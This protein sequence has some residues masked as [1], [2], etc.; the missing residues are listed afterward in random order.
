ME[1]STLRSVSTLPGQTQPLTPSAQMGDR[2]VGAC[3]FG[4]IHST[5]NI[6]QHMLPP[7]VR[8]RIHSV[9]SA[10]SG[11]SGGSSSASGQVDK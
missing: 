11:G 8:R 4:R 10:R 1:K 9:L 6:H 2:R 5:C 3:V 7:S